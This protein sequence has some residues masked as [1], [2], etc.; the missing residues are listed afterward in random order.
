MMA[1]GAR[2]FDLPTFALEINNRYVYWRPLRGDATQLGY[3]GRYVSIP[4]QSFYLNFL[5]PDTWH[6]R[7]R[8]DVR[9]LD[10]AETFS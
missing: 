8:H 7:H 9:R 3:E 1:M 2:F 6:R 5:K 10:Q 4:K